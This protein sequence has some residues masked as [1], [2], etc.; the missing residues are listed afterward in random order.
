MMIYLKL[1]LSFFQVGLFSVGGGYA[2]IALIREQVVEINN[3]LSMSDFSNLTAIAEMTPGPIAINAATFVGIKIAGLGGAFIAT[4]GCVTPS[5]LISSLLAFIY[6]K[7]KSG[8]LLKSILASIRPVTI[9]IILSAGISLL[10]NALWKNKDIGFSSLDFISLFIF[11]FS[12]IL[13]RKAKLSPILIILL[14][15]VIYLAASLILP[16]LIK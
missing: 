7:Y 11:V 13:L 2:A 9:G 1:F 14:S 10:Q 5:I 3:W 15:G 12:F 6:Y 16:L 4:L 8:D